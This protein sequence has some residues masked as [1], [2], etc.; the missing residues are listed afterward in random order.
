MFFFC[1]FFL[2]LAFFGSQGVGSSIYLAVAAH[3]RILGAERLDEASCDVQVNP[4]G[5]YGKVFATF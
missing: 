1:F 4:E 3:R 2:K 5:I